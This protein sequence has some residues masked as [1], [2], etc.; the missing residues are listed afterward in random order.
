MFDTKTLS[1]KEFTL[2]ACEYRVL[3]I[4]YADGKDIFDRVR[5]TLGRLKGSLI[6]VNQEATEYGADLMLEMVSLLTLEE[7]ALLDDRL[8]AYVEVR[9]PSPADG[10]Q[11]EYIKLRGNEAAAFRDNLMHSYVVL[12]RAFCASFL[13]SLV[14]SLSLLDVEIPGFGSPKRPT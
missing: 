3:P 1:A 10:V 12:V 6:N 5:V 13:D 11:S 2:G 8:F 4:P 14:D 7:R 9:L